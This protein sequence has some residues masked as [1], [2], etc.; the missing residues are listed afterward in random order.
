MWFDY[1]VERS[2]RTTEHEKASW[3]SESSQKNRFACVARYLGALAPTTILDVGCGT[4]EFERWFRENSTIPHSFVGVDFCD[5]FI[6]QAKKKKIPNASFGVA[7][8]RNLPF[9]VDSFPFTLSIGLLQSCDDPLL[10][11]KSITRVT[12]RRLLILTLSSC[13]EFQD[14]ISTYFDPWWLQVQL[15]HLGWSEIAISGVNTNTGRFVSI[16]R[17]HCIQLVAEK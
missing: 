17:T 14:S 13:T 7:D 11:L 9:D 16:F 15:R 2:S 4:G 10:V 5:S 3:G 6:A 1:W 12:K 8:A